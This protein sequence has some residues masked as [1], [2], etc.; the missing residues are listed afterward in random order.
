MCTS[1]NK[2][3][4]ETPAF[5][6]TTIITNIHGYKW[7][8]QIYSM[9]YSPQKTHIVNPPFSPLHA[10]T[11][12]TAEAP[13]MSCWAPAWCSL[14]GAK[15]SRPTRRWWVATNFCPS[16]P[17]AAWDQNWL[18]VLFFCKKKVGLGHFLVGSAISVAD[19]CFAA[20]F[21]ICCRIIHYCWS[22]T[23]KLECVSSL[24]DG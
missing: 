1:F 8:I 16:T 11:P 24:F 15:R 20:K 19:G 7:P 21:W 4:S 3:H 13:R 6:I 12:G 18:A 2:M 9:L 23:I 10:S 22:L 14:A 17:G 5:M